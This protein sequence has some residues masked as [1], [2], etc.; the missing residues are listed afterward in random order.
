MREDDT[1]TALAGCGNG[2]VDARAT[3]F[4]FAT[5]P[6]ITGGMQACGRAATRGGSC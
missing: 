3:R 2:D 4:A 1:S 5:Q 6:G